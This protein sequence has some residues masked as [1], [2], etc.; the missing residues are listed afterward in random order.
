MRVS[1]RLAS[2]LDLGK[3]GS[4]HL[5]LEMPKGALIADVLRQLKESR[6][7][8]SDA[9]LSTVVFMNGQQV[10]RE[11]VLDPDAEIALLQPISGG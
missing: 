4:T 5:S 11:K 1:V 10:G 9:L 8:V 7:E 6:P 2:S 3:S